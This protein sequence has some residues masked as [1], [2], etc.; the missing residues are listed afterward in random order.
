MDAAERL[1]K[2]Y[3]ALLAALEAS[4]D[5]EPFAHDLR[6]LLDPRTKSERIEAAV[7][8]HIGALQHLSS[9]YITSSLERRIAARLE[10]TSLESVPSLPAIRGY[11]GAYLQKDER[12]PP[13]LSH[14]SCG[15][16]H[17]STIGST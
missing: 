17:A 8:E 12:T 2:R 5:M 6:I 16:A 11:V 1:R 4:P 7:R 15:L 13:G 9:E 10:Q 14:S 3:S